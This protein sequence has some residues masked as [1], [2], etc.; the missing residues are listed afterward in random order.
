MKPRQQPQKVVWLICRAHF[1]PPLNRTLE[2]LFY[3]TNEKV[4]KFC[5]KL[6]N[7]IQLVHIVVALQFHSFIPCSTSNSKA[8]LGLYSICSVRNNIIPGIDCHVLIFDHFSYQEFVRYMWSKSTGQRM[9]R[10]WSGQMNSG[11]YLIRCE[12]LFINSLS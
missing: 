3:L 12:T 10:G 11:I 2:I 9:K 4:L 8:C 7:I 1:Q 6:N 5:G